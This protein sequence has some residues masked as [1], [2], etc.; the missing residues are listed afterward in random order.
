VG[1]TTAEAN[2]MINTFPMVVGG[3]DGVV[4]SQCF[5]WEVI[6]DV[7]QLYMFGQV[8]TSLGQGSAI[9]NMHSTVDCI[10]RAFFTGVK[11]LVLTSSPGSQLNRKFSCHEHSLRVSNTYLC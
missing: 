9:C 3:G 2:H 1:V 6:A 4:T 11:F 10:R 5:V 8:C 7:L